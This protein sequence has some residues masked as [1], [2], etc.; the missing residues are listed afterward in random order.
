MIIEARTNHVGI[1]ERVHKAQG[2]RI[3]RWQALISVRTATG[4][5][6]ESPS[7][8]DGIIISI[9]KQVGDR[10]DA[11]E[12]VA[13]VDDGISSLNLSDDIG[14]S[15]KSASKSDWAKFF[16]AVRRHCQLASEALLVSL[17]PERSDPTVHRALALADRIV[18]RELFPEL[19]TDSTQQTAD[20]V[21][22]QQLLLARGSEAEIERRQRRFAWSR[23]Q[24]PFLLVSLRSRIYPAPD[25]YVGPESV[26]AT[27]LAQMLF[28]FYRLMLRLQL[29]HTNGRSAILRVAKS[30]QGKSSGVSRKAAR[31]NFQNWALWRLESQPNTTQ[32]RLAKDYRSETG[33]RLT[34]ETLCRYLTPKYGFTRKNTDRS[35]R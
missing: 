29:S 30:A 2:D 32:R 27:E 33:S 13:L 17:F 28:E 1:V 7:P 4:Q 15:A 3:S 6:Y 22:L 20:E 18:L 11:N 9:K 5:C 35:R 23:Q 21:E 16:P 34:I 14:V 24:M 31:T 8:S 12:I 26:L 25:S 19:V 10:S